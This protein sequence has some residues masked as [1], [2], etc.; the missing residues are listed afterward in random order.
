MQPDVFLKYLFD[1]AIDAVSAERV[2][3]NFIPQSPK[4]K[5]VILAFGKAAVSMASVFVK[6]YNAPYEGLIVTRHGHCDYC[7]E[8]LKNFTLIEASHPI[9]YEK[10]VL[11]SEYAL[12]LVRDLGKDDLVVALISGGGSAL[13]SGPVNGITL[14]DKCSVTQKLLSCGATIEEIN[15]IR[16]HLSIIKG[17]RLAQG[18]APAKIVSLAVSGVVGNDPSQIASGPTVEDNSTLLEARDIINK[19]HIETSQ[20]I[21]NALHNISN[22]SPQLSGSDYDRQ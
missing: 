17:G 4:G 20:N 18:A 14:E 22:C 2:L 16:K 6:C 9:P 10:G 8:S 7:D 11:G 3:P 13:L 19:Y 12:K 15:C 5:T 1:V 21:F